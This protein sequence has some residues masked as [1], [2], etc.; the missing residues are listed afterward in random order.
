MFWLRDKNSMTDNFYSKIFYFPDE[1][2]AHLADCLRV[3]FEAA[4]RYEIEKIVIFTAKGDGIHL[5]LDLLQKEPKYQALKII[6]VTFPQGKRFTNR[7]N[8]DSPLQVEIDLKSRKKFLKRGVPIVQARLPF[9]PIAASF[10]DCGLLG[11]DFSLIGNALSIFGGSMS[12][13]VQAALI[14][15]D[16]GEITW[17]EHVITMT[18]D[19][20]ILV[21]AAPTGHFLTDFVV[22]EILC[23]PLFLTIG[24]KEEVPPGIS[25]E[26][27]EQREKE[28]PQ[29]LPPERPQKAQK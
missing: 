17:G 27:Q 14:A 22:R 9:D 19:T 13:C 1:G 18:S 20:A 6:A 28:P 5:A 26:E 24:K 29:L 2:R 23:K 16:A 4:T 11:Q 7:E 10:R 21:R 25:D 12:L 8:P 15:C 3:S